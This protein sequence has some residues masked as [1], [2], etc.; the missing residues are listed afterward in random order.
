M[1]RE[2]A[3][4]TT[5]LNVFQVQNIICIMQKKKNK[6][7]HIYIDNI[8]VGKITEAHRRCWL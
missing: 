4:Q 3:V 1:L 5:T 6:H 2:N 7:L 8:I